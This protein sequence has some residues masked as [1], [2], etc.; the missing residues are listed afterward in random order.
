MKR[1]FGRIDPI[2]LLCAA[3]PVIAGLV[4]M[5]S[6]HASN[7]FFWRQVLWASIAFIV[8]VAVSHLDVK[9]LSRTRI[10]VWLYGIGAGF[11]VLVLIAGST[12]NGAKSWIQFGWFSFQPS[13]L[14]KLVL[15]CVLAKY[16]SRR[17]VELAHAKHLLITASYLL[18]P[19]FLLFLQPDFGSAII[20]CVIWFGMVMV[21]GISRKHLMILGAVVLAGAVGLWLFVFQPYQKAR[22]MTFIQPLSDIHGSGYNAYQSVIAVGSGQLIGKGIDVGTQS[23]LAFLPEYH[24]DFIFAAYSEEWGFLGA[25]LILVCFAILLARSISISERGASNFETLLGIGIVCYL[26]SHMLINIGMNIGVLPVTGLPLPFMSYGG[27]H[28]LAEAAALGILMSISKDSRAAHPE[29]MRKE[30][31]GF[32]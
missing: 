15:I 16:L 21:A 7:D 18:V 10:L 24:T 25:M 32:G 2:L 13:D 1:I 8:I 22:I 9:L 6:F 23:R 27:S 29:D 11:L 12:I 28:F 5:G 19:L 17:H 26:G 3:V 20:F 14:M 30:F 4:T 31:L